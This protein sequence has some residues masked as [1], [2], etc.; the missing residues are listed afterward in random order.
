[1]EPEQSFV[2]L[3]FLT[4]AA[5]AFGAI[6]LAYLKSFKSLKD[7]AERIFRQ[8]V[9]NGEEE[10]ILELKR[11]FDG[12]KKRIFLSALSFASSLVLFISVAKR[13]WPSDSFPKTILSLGILL[14]M[15]GGPM[16]M[17]VLAD[18]QIFFLKKEIMGRFKQD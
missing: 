18:V 2:F 5:V 12:V 15:F 13:L 1:M 11:F 8:R 9:V 7:E 16:L 6:N 10:I 3:S 14:V 17:L 4:L